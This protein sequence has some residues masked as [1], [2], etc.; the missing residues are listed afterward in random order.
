MPQPFSRYM[1]MSLTSSGGTSDYGALGTMRIRLFVAAEGNTIHVSCTSYISV[2]HAPC[3]FTLI[4][5]SGLQ[6][7]MMQMIELHYEV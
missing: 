7:T 5:N 1:G 3:F 2:V 4:G 6:M